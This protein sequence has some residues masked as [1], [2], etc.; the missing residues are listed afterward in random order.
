MLL[1]VYL[2]AM[3]RDKHGGKMTK[4]KGNVIDPIDVIHGTTLEA[5]HKTLLSGNLD[6]KDVADAMR[7]QKEDYPQVGA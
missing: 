1:Q 5:L 6:A 7:G 3:V 4:S 2:H